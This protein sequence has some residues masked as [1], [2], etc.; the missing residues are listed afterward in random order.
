MSDIDT[1]PL[2]STWEGWNVGCIFLKENL[3]AESFVSIIWLCARSGDSDGRVSLAGFSV[4][5]FTFS[6]CTGA[7]QL[8]CLFLTKGIDLCIAVES[9]CLWMK[10]ESR[11][12]YSIISFTSFLFPSFWPSSHFPSVFIHSRF[13]IPLVFVLLSHMPLLLSVLYLC[14]SIPFSCSS[15]LHFFYMSVHL[16][17]LLRLHTSILCHCLYRLFHLSSFVLSLQ[18]SLSFLLFIQSEAAAFCQPFFS[19]I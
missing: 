9:V 7:S 10:G 4:A 17:L 19:F 11:T 18:P 12:S 13:Y 2:G 6:Q 8:V 14:V 3:G 16:S 15:F 1:S 5:S